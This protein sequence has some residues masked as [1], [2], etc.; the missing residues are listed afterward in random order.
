MMHTAARNNT[1]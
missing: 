1:Q